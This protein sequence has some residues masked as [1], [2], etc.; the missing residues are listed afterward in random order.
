[1]AVTVHFCMRDPATGQ[2]SLHSELAAFRYVHGT[3]SGEALAEPYVRILHELGVLGKLGLTTLDNAGNCGTMMEHAVPL[4]AKLGVTYD[5]EKNRGRFVFNGVMSCVLCV[6]LTAICQMLSS[7]RQYLGPARPC[8]PDQ[9]R[10]PAT[11]RSAR[12]RRPRICS[13]VKE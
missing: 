6:W 12:F 1:M 3:H 5:A 2:I 11:S 8:K 9:S 4:L 10:R 7:C 13:S